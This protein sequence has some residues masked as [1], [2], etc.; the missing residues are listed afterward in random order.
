MYTYIYI[1]I[2]IQV[3]LKTYGDFPAKKQ[4]KQPPWEPD[5]PQ[6]RVCPGS[7]H[8]HIDNGNDNNDN[9]DD[10]NTANS[11]DDCHNDNDTDPEAPGSYFAD[12]ARETRRRARR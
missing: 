2:Y 11:D 9:G 10:A 12:R 5:P 7:D 6:M 3:V 8:D 1:Y 4:Q